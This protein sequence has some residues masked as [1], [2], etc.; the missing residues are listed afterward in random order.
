MDKKN[1]F[2]I[3]A[4]CIIHIFN[5]ELLYLINVKGILK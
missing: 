3:F 5:L 4:I 2:I 1:K